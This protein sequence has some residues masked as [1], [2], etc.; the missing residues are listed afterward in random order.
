MII[1]FPHPPG[2]GGPGTFQRNF[3]EYL[4][5]TGWEVCYKG[6]EQKQDLI[7]IV[8]GTRYIGWLILMKIRNIP[9]V[10]RLDGI[11]WL[12]RHKKVSFKKYIHIELGILLCKFIHAFIADYI[13]YQSDF[14][15]KCWDKSGWYKR[16][17]SSVIYNGVILPSRS[18]ENSFNGNLVVLEGNIDYTPYAVKLLN[19]LSELLPDDICIHIYGNFENKNNIRLLHP[20]I[21]Y[22]GYIQHEKIYKILSG[23]IYLSLDI[24]PAC[25]NTV[26]EAMACGAPVV[27][28]DTGSLREIVPPEAGILVTYG[29]DPWKIDYPDV[30]SLVKA[31]SEIRKKY[32]YYSINS[33][34]FVQRHF[35]FENI[36]NRYF[37]IVKSFVEK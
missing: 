23:T 11:P 24:N 12:H 35:K 32:T 17:K 6:S 7:F 22:H 19:D 16:N 8:G 15:R 30:F 25:P 4:K 31:I 20:R 1:C 2:S 37:S 36:A 34:R 18:F 26:L 29:G 5:T 14:V 9:I 3:E 27:A 28:F 10:Y 33:Q 13:I 21:N